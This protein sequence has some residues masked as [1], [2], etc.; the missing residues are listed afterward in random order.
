MRKSEVLAAE[1]VA[2]LNKALCRLKDI[3]EEIGIPEDQRLQRTDVVKK[4]I[5]GLLDMMIAEEENL[6][7]RLLKSIEMCRKELDVLCRELHLTSFEEE[8]GSTVLQLEKDIRTRLEVMLKQKNQRMQE[9]KALKEQDQDLCDILCSDSYCIDSDAVPT[10]EQLDHFRHHIANLVA[11]K[12]RRRSEFVGIKRQIILCMEELDHLPDTSFERDVVCEDEEAFCLSTENIASLKLLLTQLQERKAQ[13]EA[14]C[15]AYRSQIQELWDR[16]QVPQEE[17]DVFSEHMLS[18]R[19]RNMEALQT[20]AERLQE[21]KLQNIKNVI[22]AIRVE[23]ASYWD[24]CFFSTEQRGAFA[25]YSDDD[26]TEDLLSLHD[27]EILRVKQHYEDHKELFEGVDK[28][29]ETWSLYLELEKKATDPSRFTNR[30]GNLLKEEKQRADLQK[31]LPKLERKLKTQIDVWE[32]E[33]GREFLVNGQKFLQYVEEQW[34][35]YR[36]EKER[37]KQ[38][39]QLKKSKQTEEDM[40]YGTIPRTPSK[41]RLLGTNTPGKTRKFNATSI[42]SGTSNSTMRSACGGTL[43]YSPVSRPPLSGGKQGHLARTPGHG[44]PP[45]TGLLERNKENICHLNGTALSGALRTAASP[46]RNFSI[47]SVASTYSE[48]ARELS[49]ASKSNYKTGILNSTITHNC[50]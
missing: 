36:L 43:C 18:S 15:A 16:L 17:R 41:R 50:I 49:K 21:L 26:Y 39:R 33:Q 5:K 32:Q 2:C 45:R 24:K 37:E 40:L 22:E 29:Q 34:E 23:L 27:A 11:E 13:N 7:E 20:E 42:S 48:F 6:K 46:Q 10:L 19:K 31:S 38:D 30:G 28:W 47:N 25:P 35:L 44:K 3:W 1:S 4:H 8:E 12:E 9:L 14:V